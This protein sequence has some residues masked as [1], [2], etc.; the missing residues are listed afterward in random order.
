[1]SGS[2]F[3]SSVWI[4]AIFT[5]H[6]CHEQAQSALYEATPAAPAVFCRSTQQSVLRLASTP[7]LLKAYGADGLTNRDALVALE[8][9]LALPQVC[10]REEPP[11]T[12]ALWHRLAGRDT[13]SPKVWMDA[14]L[15]AFAISSGLRLVTLDDDFKNYEA[16]GLDWV[17]LKP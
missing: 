12:V 16:Q 9:L 1:V 11:G 7:A 4:A 2:L 6:P 15:A 8:A 17:V 13:A 3:D 10:E 14:Y 5:T